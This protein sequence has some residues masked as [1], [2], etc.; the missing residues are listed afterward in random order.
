[1]KQ[2][3]IDWLGGHV[4]FWDL[5]ELDDTVAV[6]TQIECLKEDLVQV[7]YRDCMLDVGWY[8][9]FVLDGAFLVK[10]VS[11]DWERTIFE[12]RVTELAE[13]KPSM[14]RAAR[15]ASDECGQ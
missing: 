11:L 2:D 12:E 1:M 13:L 15:I 14:Q 8:P 9:S 7:R 5:S 4:A 10:V 6:A 3:E